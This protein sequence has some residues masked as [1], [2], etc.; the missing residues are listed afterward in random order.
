MGEIVNREW[1]DRVPAIPY[2]PESE[3]YDLEFDLRVYATSVTRTVME[4]R[5]DYGTHNI[6]AVGEFGVA[7]R[8]FDK[9]NRL[10]NLLQSG[11]EPNHEALVDTWRDIVGYGLIGM[12]L[13]KKGK[14]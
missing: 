9:V 2:A 3:E 7:V 6:N 8:L 4:K 13:N 11:E 12:T 10:V 1:L 5:D 14:W